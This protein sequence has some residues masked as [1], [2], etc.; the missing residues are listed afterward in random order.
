MSHFL[1][2]VVNIVIFQVINDELKDTFLIH[3]RTCVSPHVFY[4][5]H[6]LSKVRFLNIMIELSMS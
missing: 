1:Q 4:L 3:L 2:K 6:Q 5:R